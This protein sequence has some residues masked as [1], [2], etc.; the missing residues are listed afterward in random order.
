MSVASNALWTSG[1][2]RV[3]RATDPPGPVRSTRRP[4]PAIALTAASYGSGPGQPASTEVRASDDDALADPGETGPLEVRRR[5]GARER[6]GRDE[7][8]AV[9]GGESRAGRR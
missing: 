5:V 4:S 9:V 2:A 3:T 1:R 8:A 7:L 6:P